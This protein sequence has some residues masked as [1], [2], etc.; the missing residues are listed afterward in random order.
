[1]TSFIL[2][3]DDK[4]MHCK[5]NLESKAL[6]NSNLPQ[7]FVHIKDVGQK[8][9]AG[10]LLEAKLVHLVVHVDGLPGDLLAWSA[11]PEEPG[12]PLEVD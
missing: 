9:F 1:M 5:K 6:E 7:V 11:H 3:K 2:H 10:L 12:H 8:A 4:V